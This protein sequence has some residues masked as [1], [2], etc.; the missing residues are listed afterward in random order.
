MELA[1]ITP[2]E[3]LQ[4]QKNGAVLIDLSDAC[5]YR[6]EHIPDSVSQPIKTI[7]EKGLPAEAKQ[8]RELVFLCRVGIRTGMAAPQLA[9]LCGARKGYILDNGLRSWKSAQLPTRINRAAPIDLMRQ[10]QIAAG[11]LT[12]LGAV[13]GWFVSPYFFGL[14]AFVG[15][16]LTM[17][18]MTGWCGM[19]M[20]LSRMPW[21]R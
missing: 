16:G 1:K 12:L 4:K 13:L 8:A 2:E 21:N 6:R 14:C 17:A 15:L 9:E 5:D 7:Q 19:A 11:S 10:V 18:G 3:A 20:L